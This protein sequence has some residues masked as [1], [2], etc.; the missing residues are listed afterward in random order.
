VWFVFGG[1][2][3]VL[4]LF[5]FISSCVPFLIALSVFSNIYL[6]QDNL[7]HMENINSVVQE[8]YSRYSAPSVYRPSVL[9]PTFSSVPISTVKNTSLYCQTQL[10][11][12]ATGFQTKVVKPI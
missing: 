5:C 7:P 2:Q 4:F 10:P 6:L 12:S 9:L 1:G 3:H 11:P 8:D